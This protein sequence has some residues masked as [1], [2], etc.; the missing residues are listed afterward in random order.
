MPLVFAQ[1]ESSL[2]TGFAQVAVWLVV[3]AVIVGLYLVIRRTRRK[4][5]RQFLDRT[6]REEEMRR[7]D[8]DIRDQ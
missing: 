3:A 7:N 8:P 2:S 6:R 5:Q 4:A 1:A